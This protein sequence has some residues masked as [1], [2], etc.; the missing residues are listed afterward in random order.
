MVLRETPME[1]FA[2]MFGTVM[3]GAFL[4][5]TP[6]LAQAINIDYDHSVDFRQYKSYHWE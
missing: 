3:F 2:K 1:S 6:L 5:G 4:L